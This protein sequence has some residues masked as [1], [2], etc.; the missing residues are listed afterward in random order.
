MYA[1]HNHTHMICNYAFVVPR[2]P[3]LLGTCFFLSRPPVQHGDGMLFTFQNKITCG[4]H[5]FRCLC[6]ALIQ[7]LG[8]STSITRIIFLRLRRR[9]KTPN[10]SLQTSPLASNTKYPK[11]IIAFSSIVPTTHVLLS[12]N[13]NPLHRAEIGPSNPPDGN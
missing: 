11:D 13:P 3:S 6:Y 4:R 12:S 8:S 2:T 9:Y 1:A 7:S 5:A 10:V